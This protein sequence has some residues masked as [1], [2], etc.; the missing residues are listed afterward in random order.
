MNVWQGITIGWH[1]VVSFLGSVVWWCFLACL[2]I[3]VIELLV[4][5]RKKR[6]DRQ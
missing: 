3:F 1:W 2:V 6:R 5:R 4:Y